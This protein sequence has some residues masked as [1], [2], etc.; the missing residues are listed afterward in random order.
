MTRLNLA[1]NIEKCK[2]GSK[3]IYMLGHH[4]SEKGLMIDKSKLMDIDNWERL[5]TTKGITT[6]P[7]FL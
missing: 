2:L 7:W 4:I 3:S 1:L 6:F 5:T